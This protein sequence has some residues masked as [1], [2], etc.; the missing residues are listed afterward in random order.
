MNATGTIVVSAASPPPSCEFTFD[1]KNTF[2][3][4]DFSIEIGDTP[5]GVT[6][7]YDVSGL[8]AG[9]M[10]G[11]SEGKL[12]ISGIPYAFP[13]KNPFSFKWRGGPCEGRPSS[14]EIELEQ[15]P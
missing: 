5:Q 7:I 15:R 11:V 10:L 9:T 2:I 14:G 6:D 3:Y 12:I 1:K 4:E 8:P 13:G